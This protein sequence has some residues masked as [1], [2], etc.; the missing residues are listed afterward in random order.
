MDPVH[1]R[2]HQERHEPPFEVDRQLEVAVVKDDGEGEH[3]LPQPQR[4]AIDPQQQHLRRPEP[5]RQ[6]QLAE[7]EPQPGGAVEIQIDV[8]DR[9]KPPQERHR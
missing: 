8:V 4:V 6:R 3:L 2:R 9:V 5:R 1:P 7:M